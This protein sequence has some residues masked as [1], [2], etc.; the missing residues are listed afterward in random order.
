MEA[1]PRH[2]MPI[3]FSQIQGGVEGSDDAK[4]SLL[5]YNLSIYHM[6]CLFIFGIK[7]MMN[8]LHILS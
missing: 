2:M 7:L 6:S 1:T 3:G 4:L 8:L 5:C